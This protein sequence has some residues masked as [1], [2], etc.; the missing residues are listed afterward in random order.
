MT[1]VALRAS[2][3]GALLVVVGACGEYPG[4]PHALAGGDVLLASWAGPGGTAPQQGSPGAPASGGGAKPAALPAATINFKDFELDP[5]EVT[6]A[7]GTVRFTLVNEGRYTHD[8]RVEGNGV[9]QNS[10]RIGAGRTL[11]WELALGPGD[12]KISCPISNHADRGMTGTLV[13]LP[14]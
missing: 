12:Y 9:D 7:A 11:T 3:L 5:N 6:V 13:V 14:Q 2:L 8:F 10:P 4:V 1:R